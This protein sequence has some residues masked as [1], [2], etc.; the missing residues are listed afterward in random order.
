[1]FYA[2]SGCIKTGRIETRVVALW[3]SLMH[4]E[5]YGY[6]DNYHQGL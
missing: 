5:H 2:S 1:M 6:L 3:M 4:D